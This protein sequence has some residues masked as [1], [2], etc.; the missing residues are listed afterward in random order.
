[1]AVFL[2][3]FFFLSFFFTLTNVNSVNRINVLTEDNAQETQVSTA[4]DY[5]G[6]IYGTLVNSFN[7]LKNECDMSFS[8]NERNNI[9]DQEKKRINERNR[10][11][12]QKKKQEKEEK[13]N[14]R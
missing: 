7:V 3:H 8:C 10:R 9:T 13:Q 11:K 12:K 2:L 4:E 1:M 14:L 5:S 6:S